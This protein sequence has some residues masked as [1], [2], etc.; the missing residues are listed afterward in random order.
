MDRPWADITNWRAE[1]YKTG[2][3]DGST[4]RVRADGADIIGTHM[5]IQLGDWL[6]EETARLIAASPDLYAALHE[7]TEIYWGVDDDE[8]GDGISPPPECIIRARAAL[9][10]ALGKET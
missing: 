10:K 3:D 4:W 1:K 9:N 2:I 6:T 5:N 8:N 7:L